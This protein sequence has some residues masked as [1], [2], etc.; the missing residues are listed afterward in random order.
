MIIFDYVRRTHN[1]VTLI[2]RGLQTSC[3]HRESRRMLWRLK[4]DQW[5]VVPTC[6][7]WFPKMFAK[8]GHYDLVPMVNRR[9]WILD[10]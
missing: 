3:Q 9:A 5:L 2:D 1:V 10:H 8:D 7:F 6:R 4:N